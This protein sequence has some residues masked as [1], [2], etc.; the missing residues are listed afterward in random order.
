[1]TPNQTETLV[2]RRV[3]YT[4]EVQGKLVIIENVPKQVNSSSLLR[5]SRDFS[6]W[7][8]VRGSRSGRFRRRCTTSQFD[9]RSILHDHSKYETPRA[10]P[11][12][13]GP[14]IS[15]KIVKKMVVPPEIHVQ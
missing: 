2:E 11:P 7:R 5:R 8:G 3:T 13:V 1:M 6:R 10:P 12:G 9:Y 4:L 15:A 14:E